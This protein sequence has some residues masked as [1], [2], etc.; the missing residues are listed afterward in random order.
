MRQ[1]EVDSIANDVS[2]MVVNRVLAKELTIN[3]A[4]TGILSAPVFLYSKTLPDDAVHNI[5]NKGEDIAVEIMSL[6]KGKSVSPAVLT[7]ALSLVSRGITE[8]TI[9]K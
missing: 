6:L 3:E 7:Y 9:N 5:L 8:N 1:S 2:N 4:L